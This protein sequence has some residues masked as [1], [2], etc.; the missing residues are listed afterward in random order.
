MKS[1]D[2]RANTQNV[3]DRAR[4]LLK[5]L[6]GLAGWSGLC[7]LAQQGPHAQLVSLS[8]TVMTRVSAGQAANTPCSSS[9]NQGRSITHHPQAVEWP[10]TGSKAAPGTGTKPRQQAGRRA[11]I[12]T[13]LTCTFLRR[14]PTAAS[15]VYLG[16]GR[17]AG[18]LL[19]LLMR[20]V[21]STSEIS[22]RPMNL[23]SDKVAVPPR[24]WRRV[25]GLLSAPLGHRA[26]SGHRCS[27]ARDGASRPQHVM[28]AFQHLPPDPHLQSILHAACSV[29]ASGRRSMADSTC[30]SA[31]LCWVRLHTF[32]AHSAAW[33]AGVEA[34]R[35]AWKR[36]RV[37]YTRTRVC[38]VTATQTGSVKAWPHL[39]S[40]PLLP[41][42]PKSCGPSSACRR[43]RRRPL[44]PPPAAAFACP[45]S[46][47]P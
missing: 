33:G 24:R 7:W 31:L 5:Q 27:M 3:S 28:R 39:Q 35:G 25:V 14:G 36:V 13:S 30:L 29:M 16:Q 37:M 42:T 46:A 40:P 20:P 32:H 4:S 15:T 11:G 38:R 34:G 26:R 45:A 12:C 44:L 1:V 17:S 8:I 41:S 22:P 43:R 21:R 19:R 10:G 9:R 6:Q 2:E 47:W 18:W 23:R